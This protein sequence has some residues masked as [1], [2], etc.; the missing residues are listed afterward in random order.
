VSEQ[1]R[2]GDALP[3][4]RP[5]PAGLAGSPIGRELGLL[6]EGQ[7]RSLFD[8]SQTNRTPE[9]EAFV[10]ETRRAMPNAGTLLAHSTLE[11]STLHGSASLAGTALVIRGIAKAAPSAE[12]MTRVAVAA[13]HAN[14]AAAALIT[15]HATEAYRGPDRARAVAGIQ[16][17]AVSTQPSPKRPVSPAALPRSERRYPVAA[18]RDEPRSTAARPAARER[19]AVRDRQIER[20]TSR[21]PPPKQPPGRQPEKS[22]RNEE[23]HP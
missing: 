20:G 19:I 15:R 17:A 16:Q 11:A 21:R 8:G 1:T 10:A 9:Q 18:R 12:V 5:L 22:R 13:I 6:V 3:R 7:R 2:R 14:P 23:G 4:G